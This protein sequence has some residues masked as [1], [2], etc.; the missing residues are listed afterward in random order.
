MRKQKVV[1][2]KKGIAW[3]K[4]HPTPNRMGDSCLISECQLETAQAQPCA[5]GWL[6]TLLDG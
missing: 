6:N 2:K 4:H 3:P 5:I 1:Q